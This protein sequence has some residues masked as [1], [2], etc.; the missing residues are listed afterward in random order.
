MKH[1]LRWPKVAERPYV[2]SE[3]GRSYIHP[4]QLAL[5]SR[6]HVLTFDDLRLAAEIRGRARQG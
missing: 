1:N 6:T 2:C 4:M 5:H 3:C